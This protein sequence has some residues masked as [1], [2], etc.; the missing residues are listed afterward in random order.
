MH[1]LPN[2]PTVTSM[3]INGKRRLAYAY[4]DGREAIE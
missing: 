3:I 2:E 1:K 4:P